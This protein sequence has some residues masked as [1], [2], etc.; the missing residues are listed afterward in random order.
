MARTRRT[1]KSKVQR[2]LDPSRWAHFMFAL[3]GFM[4]AWVLTH[5]IE[6]M[7]AVVWSYWPQLKRPDTVISNVAGIVIALVATVIAW[8]HERWFKFC[9]EVVVEIS[10]VTW[11]NKAE[12][13]AATVVVI[14]LTLICSGILAGMD[15]FWSSV[16][17]W[18]YGS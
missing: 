4:A 8:R 14:V 15:T 7:W 12:T 18:L 17:D 3:G 2:D 11:P 6:D 10:Q 5:F 1:K 9:C 16:T 13:R